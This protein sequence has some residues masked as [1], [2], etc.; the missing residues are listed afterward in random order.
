[1][2]N[3]ANARGNQNAPGFCFTTRPGTLFGA[4]PL[5]EQCG[6]SCCPMRR[7]RSRRGF[8]LH[9]GTAR[10]KKCKTE[11][12]PMRL[13]CYSHASLC[14]H[15]ANTHRT[16]MRHPPNTHAMLTRGCRRQQAGANGFGGAERGDG[17]GAIPGGDKVNHLVISKRLAHGV[18]LPHVFLGFLSYS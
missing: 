7:R 9:R 12:A 16:P 13:P 4:R 14:E 3:T 15:P 18:I 17:I 8:L 5:A 10:A 6:K 2:R 11:A 1:M